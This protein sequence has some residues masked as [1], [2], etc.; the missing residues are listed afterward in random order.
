MA[1][2]ASQLQLLPVRP[3]GAPP[4]V[5]AV[6]CAGDRHFAPCLRHHALWEPAETLALLRMLQ[7]GMTVVDVGAHV[8]YYSVL[9]AQRVGRAGRVIAFEPEAQN[10]RLLHA[11]LLLNDCANVAVHASAVD[12]AAGT[13]VTSGDRPPNDRRTV[14]HVSH[15]LASR[16]DPV[17][18]AVRPVAARIV[19]VRMTCGVDVIAIIT[20]A[21]GHGVEVVVLVAGVARAFDGDVIAARIRDH[22][23]PPFDQ[24]EILPILA[25]QRRDQPVVVEGEHDLRRC[26]GRR[27]HQGGAVGRAAGQGVTILRWRSSCGRHASAARSP[28]FRKDCWSRER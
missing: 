5:L 10:R 9:C 17:A 6:E 13:E 4:F 7:P 26:V 27:W 2:A 23:E 15:D 24:R 8:G 12:A 14:G 16:V 18:V 25:E 1:A 11:N 28:A 21:G 22:A 20:T 19:G 3:P